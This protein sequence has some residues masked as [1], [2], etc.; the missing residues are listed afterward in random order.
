[1]LFDV[2]TETTNGVL[3]K[4]SKF[5]PENAVPGIQIFCDQYLKLI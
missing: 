4:D 1:M 2:K 3:N 5:W